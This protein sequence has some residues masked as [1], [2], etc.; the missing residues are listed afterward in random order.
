[1][2]KDYNC[3]INYHP[4]KAN[5]VTDALSRKHLVCM[6]VFIFGRAPLMQRF[7]LERVRR[8]LEVRLT[9]LSLQLTLLDSIKK[10]QRSDEYL[11]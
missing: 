4:G 5:V 11:M 9:T 1:M 3:E 7:S 8:S 2:I 10:K 6:I